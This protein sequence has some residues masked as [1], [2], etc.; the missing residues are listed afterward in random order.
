MD[1]LLINPKNIISSGHDIMPPLGL[2]S[3]GCVL[4]KNS[5]SV[6]ILDLEIRPGDFDI[7]A[8]ISSLSPKIVGVSGTSFTRFESFRI[9]NIAKEVSNEIFTIYGGCHATF[10]AEDTLSHVKDIDYIVHGE[11]EETLLELVSCLIAKKVDTTNIKGISSRRDGKVIENPPRERIADL[12]SIP[13]SRHLLEMEE[14]DQKLDFLNVP[15]VTIMTSR[16]CLYNCFFCSARAMFGN[17][18]VRRSAKNVVDEIQYC[19]DEFGAQGIKFFDSTL[20]LNRKHV[21]SIA[22]ELKMRG[23]NLPWECEIRVDTVDRLLLESM[24]EAGCYYVDF[25]VESASEKVLKAINK[26]ISVKQAIDVLKWCKDLDIKTKA[27]FTFGHPGETLRD[28]MMTLGFIDKYFDY[29]SW[30]AVS[31]EV[32]IYPGTPLERYARENGL[33]PKSFSWSEN[34]EKSLTTTTNIPVLLQPSFGRKEMRKVGDR[35][36]WILLSKNLDFKEYL[37]TYTLKKTLAKLNELRPLPRLFGYIIRKVIEIFKVI[38]II[39]FYRKRK[40]K[41]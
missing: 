33:L 35:L 40:E 12:D 2:S 20:T 9:A 41:S 18:Y 7:G 21:L 6:K 19:V 17:V 1:V 15:A 27:F 11:G 22:E 14:Y 16:G 4:E 39:L 30:P 3:L 36:Q 31:T 13:Y 38:M 37:K 10:T 5:F 29:I 23:I 25:G 34:I 26:N 32:R 28:S 8:Y 24:R